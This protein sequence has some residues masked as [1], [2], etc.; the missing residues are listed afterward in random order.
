MLSQ[1]PISLCIKKASSMRTPWINYTSKDPSNILNFEKSFNIVYIPVG[2]ISL[3]CKTFQFVSPAIILCLLEEK[4]SF[5]MFSNL[6]YKNCQDK[7]I[8]M[9]AKY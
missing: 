6:V 1:F 2:K 3:K 5:E 7:E 8:I 4:Q 9:E